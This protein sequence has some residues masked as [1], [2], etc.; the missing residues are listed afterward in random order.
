MVSESLFIEYIDSYRKK[1]KINVPEFCHGICSI[2]NYSRYLSRELILPFDIFIKMIHR[3]G[4]TI[5]DFVIFVE[6]TIANSN[7]DVAYFLEYVRV[8]YYQ[9]AE[10]LLKKSLEKPIPYYVESKYF[11]VA[12]ETYLFKMNQIHKEQYKV[13]C[14]EI[15]KLDSLLEQRVITREDSEALILYMQQ[16]DD[17]DKN[18]IFEYLYSLITHLDD[19][20]LITNTYALT[21][22]KISGGLMYKL[23]TQETLSKTEME[24]YKQILNFS[25]DYYFR[26]AING[27]I[28]EYI[29]YYFSYYKKINHPDKYQLLRYL[30]SLIL[31]RQDSEILL[32]SLELTDDAFEYYVNDI[33][34]NRNIDLNVIEWVKN[35]EG[36]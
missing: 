31:V 28:V 16:A 33:L 36:L 29:D 23:I 20:Q 3:L 15:I 5:K 12:K 14:R 8:G 27:H 18:R 4:W 13:R 22:T 19:Y 17:F 6:N 24:Q 21:I 7:L 26:D 2:R 35:H 34:N 1:S 10:A 25:F 9:E 32:K 30:V 11:P